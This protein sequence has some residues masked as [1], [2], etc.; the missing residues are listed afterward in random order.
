MLAAQTGSIKLVQTLLE[1]AASI[2]AKDKRGLTALM[3]AG[4]SFSADVS[5]ALI[6]AAASVNETDAK[7][8]T[9]LMHAGRA[10]AHCDG[11]SRRLV[12]GQAAAA[13]TLIFVTRK[14]RVTRLVG[15]KPVTL[16]RL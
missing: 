3:Y 11:G 14:A 6:Q 15:K 4:Q 9:A 12:T 5:K 10:R 16:D 1:S 7:G 13:P 2:G 8:W